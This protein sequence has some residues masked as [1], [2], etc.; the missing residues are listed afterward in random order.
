MV[1]RICSACCDLAGNTYVCWC[2]NKT[3]KLMY[4]NYP[5]NLLKNLCQT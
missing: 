4:F 2:A 3:Y 1:F 5:Y